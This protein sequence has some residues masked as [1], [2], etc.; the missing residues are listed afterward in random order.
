MMKFII[1]GSGFIARVHATSLSLIEDAEVVAVVDTNLVKAKAL[2][3]EFGIPHIYADWKAA[4]STGEADAAVIC[5]PHALHY[6]CA[7]DAL[8]AG[9][10]VFI[11]KP[12]AISTRQA[13]EI[14]ALAAKKQRTL[15]VGHMKRFDRRFIAMKEQ[16]AAGNLGEIFMA[17]SEWIGAREITTSLPWINDLNGGGAVLM[18]FGS[19]HIELLQWLVGPIVQVSCRVNHKMY[20]KLQVEDSA[21]AVVEFANGAIGSVIYTW[22]AAIEAQSENLD[23]YGTRGLLRLAGED[24]W[25]ISED[26]YGDRQLHQ[27][28]VLRAHALDISKFGKELALSSLEPFML[29]M[30]HFITCVNDHTTPCIDGA[31]AASAVEIINK[32]YESAGVCYTGEAK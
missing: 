11:E 24:L 12:I 3:E 13:N 21:V 29:E 9:L 27:I 8:Q 25:Q 18:G 28:D 30:Q 4:F 2:A 15:M 26:I 6:Q 17:K 23:I 1:V 31:Q 16:I 20:E 10:H 5:L 19:H 32:A 7:M 14:V 22:A